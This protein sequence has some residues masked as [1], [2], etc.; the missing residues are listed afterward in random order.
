MVEGGLASG[1]RSVVTRNSK[2]ESEMTG[3]RI[4]AVLLVALMIAAPWSSVSADPI[5]YTIKFV[6]SS[7]VG[8]VPFS[9]E[10][11]V[12][13]GVTD[14]DTVAALIEADPAQLAQLI[15]AL[16]YVTGFGFLIASIVKFKEHKDNPTQ[17][18]F[19]VEV[20]LSSPVTI[21]AVRDGALVSLTI[22]S[23]LDNRLELR[24]RHVAGGL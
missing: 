18:R 22:D 5:L 10:P 9:D 19:G 13:A 7:I 4:V 1:I 24:T 6:A 2:E 21:P 17:Q 23:I 15:A 8:G 14:T 11:F 20:S 3:S 16:S 12:F